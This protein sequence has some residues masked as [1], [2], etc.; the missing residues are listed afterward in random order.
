MKDYVK[1][2]FYERARF[3]YVIGCVDRTHVRII[4]PTESEPDYVNRTGYHD[5]SIN[6]QGIWDHGG[7]I[8]IYQSMFFR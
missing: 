8:I 7:I 4:S 1:Q 6:V 5:H 3:P 2:G